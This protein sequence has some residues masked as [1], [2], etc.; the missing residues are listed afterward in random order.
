MQNGRITPTPESTAR[1]PLLSSPLVPRGGAHCHGS[2][3]LESAIAALP[4]GLSRQEFSAVVMLLQQGG[5]AP[6]RS[7]MLQQV[8][9]GGRRYSRL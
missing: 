1:A 6:R 4:W 7:S 8:E 5:A 9:G 2:P 3:T